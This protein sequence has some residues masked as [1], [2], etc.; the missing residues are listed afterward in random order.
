[1]IHINFRK[2]IALIL[3]CCISAAAAP[4]AGICSDSETAGDI[5]GNGYINISDAVILQKYL[6]GSD[7]L[8]VW[9]NADLCRDGVIDTFDM[10]MLRKMLVSRN[11]RIIR[12]TDTE[13]LKSALEK[14]EAG[15]EIVLAEGEYIYSGSTPKGRMFTGEADGTVLN[16][17][18]LRS[19]N[20]E[21]PA[22][23]S[24]TTTESNYALTIT[25]DY[26]IIENI[27]V[28]NASKGIII[29]NS[30]N[31]KLI[32]CE[33]YNIGAEGI[34]FRDNSSYCTADSC[35]IHDTGVLSPA[36]G[37]GIYVGSAKSTTGY[38]FNCHYNVIR[39]CTIGPYVAAEH[40]DVKEYTIG[41]VIE[42]CTFDGRG[43]SG[44][45]S[46]KSFVNIKGNDCIL[47]N[48]TGYRNGC[49]K[50]TR[51][52]ESNQVV[53]G[54]GQ[55]LYIYGNKAYM[56]TAVNSSGGKMYFLNAWNCSATVWDN[57]IAYEDGE[58]KSVDNPSDQWNYYNTKL[59]TYGNSSMN[60]NY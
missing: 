22:V 36:Y 23:I 48:C 15:D 60:T 58:L 56:D 41:T 16:P 17:I 37:E 5:D 24:G 33:V 31:T 12:V 46:S 21:N 18:I 27:K 51:A 20:P 26:W 6:L 52:F 7:N 4:A 10:I 39:N 47:R 43:M 45:N 25:G 3:S 32:N 2:F 49:D 14:A 13:T 8:T 29:D 28:T 54:W 1:M 11:T 19:E 30:N 42:N 44:E 55:N 38:G 57:F 40:I 53:D 59:L 50:I 9:E 34:H 35:N